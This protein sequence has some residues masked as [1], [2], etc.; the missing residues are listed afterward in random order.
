MYT[1]C[2]CD[3]T[4]SRASVRAKALLFIILL[5]L[6]KNIFRTSGAGSDRLVHGMEINETN[7]T[8]G[9]P[10]TMAKSQVGR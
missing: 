4:V 3:D 1:H 9:E 5:R 6:G 7:T 10:L 8:D 2:H